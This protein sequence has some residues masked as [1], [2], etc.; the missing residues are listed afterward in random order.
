[1]NKELDLGRVRDVRKRKNVA[2]SNSEI[3]FAWYHLNFSIASV[4]KT[5]KNFIP[6]FVLL[7][8]SLS[9]F[10]YRVCILVQKVTVLR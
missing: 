8:S 3:F 9:D 5:F 2:D 7:I 6:F 10:F 4:S 1:M